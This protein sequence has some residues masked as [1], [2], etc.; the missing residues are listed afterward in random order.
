VHS[1]GWA[2][3]DD[4]DQ[5]VFEA[6][7]RDARRRCLAHASALGV[8][9]RTFDEQLAPHVCRARQASENAQEVVSV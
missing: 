5:A 9:R 6:E 1:L 3:V 2:L 7:G 4:R 8:L